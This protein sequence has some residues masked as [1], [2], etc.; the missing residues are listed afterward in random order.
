[1]AFVKV[2]LD[3]LGNEM[4]SSLVEDR[5]FVG[6]RDL[7]DL[8]QRKLTKQQ[9]HTYLLQVMKFPTAASNEPNAYLWS[10]CPT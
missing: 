8:L 9:E 2:T 4:K 5:A 7:K 3:S 1:V 6:V 10:Y